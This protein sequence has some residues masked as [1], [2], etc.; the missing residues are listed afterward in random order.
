MNE[1]HF[2]AAL[3]EK[4]LNVTDKQMKQFHLYYAT[5]IEWNKKMNLTAITEKEEVYEKHFYDSISSG[6]AYDF[7]TVNHICDVGAG[8]GFPSIP[9]KICYPHLQVTIV[10]SLKKRTTFLQ[11]V[12]QTLAL[13]EVSIYHDRAETFA[14]QTNFRETFDLVT[15]RAVARLSVLSELCLPLVRKG[16][17]FLVMK[18][19]NLDDELADGKRALSLLGGELV[20]RMTIHLPIEKSKRTILLIKKIKKTPK[21][22][23][24]KPGTPNRTPL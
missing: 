3:V 8:A 19:P 1:S 5:L 20:E 22:Y 24:R 6:F 23:P 18:G 11:H 13:D 10:D 15:A 21:R 17:M 2:Q 12:V 14:Q 7:S 16:G 4:G 9:L